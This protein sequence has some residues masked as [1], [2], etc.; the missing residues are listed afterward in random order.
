MMKNHNF[1]AA[2][3]DSLFTANQYGILVNSELMMLDVANSFVRSFVNV[4]SVLSRV[5]SPPY[6]WLV[7]FA[8]KTTIFVSL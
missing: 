8:P 2:F 1:F 3:R 4:F 6:E 5:V 7:L